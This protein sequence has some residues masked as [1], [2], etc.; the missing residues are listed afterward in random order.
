MTGHS[1]DYHRRSLSIPRRLMPPLLALH[2]GRRPEAVAVEEL[3]SIGVIATDPADRHRLDPLVRDLVDV[4]TNP[5]LVVAAEITAENGMRESAPRLATF[6]RKGPRAVIGLTGDG[7]Q[8]QLIAAEPAL[9]PFHVAQAVRLA[10]RRHPHFA[11][12]FSMPNALL[13]RAKELV[14]VDP[15]GLA[16]ELSTARVPR[17][18]AERLIAALT[19][20]R[21]SWVLDSVW[22]HTGT[23]ST[24]LCVLDG[25]FSG[26]W[27]ID[28]QPDG[29]LTITPAHFDHVLSRIAAML[30]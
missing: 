3:R 29:L 16:A 5:S 12:S 15:D 25:G 20:R 1:I 17:R 11:G 30:P 28:E 6:W 23:T 9:L 13:A 21:S 7:R 2:G 22:L 24:R 10:P 14:F 26:F 19:L 8:F 4:I 27:T 18:W